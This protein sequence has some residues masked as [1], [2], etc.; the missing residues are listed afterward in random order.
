MAIYQPAGESEHSLADDNGLSLFA[1]TVV[2][3]VPGDTKEDFSTPSAESSDF[4]K[5]LLLPPRRP[6]DLGCLGDYRVSTVLGAG[7]MGVVLAAHDPLLN[8]M[9]AI[10]V[11][12]PEAVQTPR[13][14]ERFLRE[15]RSAAAVEHPRVVVIHQVGEWNGTP[16]LV[17]PLLAGRSLAARSREVPPLPLGDAVRFVRET[18]DGLAA[19]H[20]RGVF[21]RDIKPDNIWLEQTNEGTHVR[22]LDFGLARGELDVLTE[23]GRLLGTPFYMAP[24]QAAGEPVTARSDL[25]GLGCVL[26]ELLSGRKP[27][28]GPTLMAVLNALAN[29]HPPRLQDVSPS[30]PAPLSQL[31]MRLLEK[32]ALRRPGSAAEVA[33]ELREIE[34]VLAAG[35]KANTLCPATTAPGLWRRILSIARA[36]LGRR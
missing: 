33:G 36:A 23:P 10:K 5:S 7:G 21:H 2:G 20:A 11:L 29:H 1:T 35:A 19:A 16:F 4:L 25:F 15:A 8:R 34:T 17:M 14:K 32:S 12:R 6:G 30:V 24:E 27:F 3:L 22:L 31:T 28:S 9:I 18:A 26:Y 13:A